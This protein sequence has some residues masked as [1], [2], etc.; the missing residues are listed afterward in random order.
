MKIVGQGGA[1]RSVQGDPP[2]PGD[3]EVAQGALPRQEAARRRRQHRPRR[4]GAPAAPSVDLCG[5]VDAGGDRRIRELAAGGGPEEVA[6]DALGQERARRQHG[7]VHRHEGLA[8]SPTAS[9]RRA[10]CRPCCRTRSTRE[11]TSRCRRSRGRGRCGTARSRRRRPTSTRRSGAHDKNSTAHDGAA[12]MLIGEARSHRRAL[13]RAP[14]PPQPAQSTCC[15]PSRGSSRRSCR[16]IAARSRRSPP[17]ASAAGPSSR[18]P[19][20]ASALPKL[21]EAKKKGKGKKARCPRTRRRRCAISTSAPRRRR[22]RAAGT[23]RGRT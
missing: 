5:R 7:H 2:R 23:R 10:R 3:E 8:R 12:I 15:S 9:S 11:R 1:G 6:G 4:P 13:R 16:C 17:V 20:A 22:A 18:W 14:Q 21:G 19:A